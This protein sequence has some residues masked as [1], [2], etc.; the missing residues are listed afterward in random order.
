V[1]VAKLCGRFVSPET[2][3]SGQDYAEYDLMSF[4]D[5][6]QRSPLPWQT[7]AEGEIIAVEALCPDRPEVRRA[8][9]N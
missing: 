1:P 3:F 5:H 8:A 4:E 9:G 7:M 2:C 6:C